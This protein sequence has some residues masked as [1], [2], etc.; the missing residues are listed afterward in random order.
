M[1]A[2][3]LEQTAGETRRRPGDG[4]SSAAPSNGIRRVTLHE[5]IV[6]RL[7]DMILDGSLPAGSHIGE[8]AIGAELGVS[9]TP[10][11]E[12]FKTLA[13][14]GL[15]EFA[16][17]KGAFVPAISAQH[18]RDILEVLTGIEGVAGR[19]AAVRATDAEIAEIRRMQDQMREHF[20]RRDRLGY[21]KINLDIH[22]RI[23]ELSHNVELVA[24]HRQ[25]AARV[26]RL[27]FNGSSTPDMWSAAVDEHEAM[28]KA[29]ERRDAPALETV[30]REHL[31]LIWQRLKSLT[32]DSSR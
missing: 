32:D 19:L 28:T 21:Y 12:A 4:S 8:T 24:M 23:V 17:G 29:L 9:R 25:A 20:E 27:R 22:R 16:A 15:I 11:R 6:T 7:R 3:T 31:G 26:Q 18:T 13:G 5:Q 2:R 30:L 1:A 10:L 14:E